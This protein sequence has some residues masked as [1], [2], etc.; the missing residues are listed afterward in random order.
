L[1]RQDRISKSYPVGEMRII[2]V[3]AGAVGSY[4]AQRLSADGQD[5]TVID[6]NEKSAT[7]LQDTIDALFLVGNGATVGTLQ[8]A[9]AESADLLI[10]VTS[11]DGANILSCYTATQL[12]T[13]TTIARIEDPGLKEG[14]DRLGVDFIIDPSLTAADEIVDVVGH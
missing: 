2:I 6:D 1:R 9:G 3:G 8:Q 5:V 7:E 10:A 13:T 12:G 14:A 11:N 4:L